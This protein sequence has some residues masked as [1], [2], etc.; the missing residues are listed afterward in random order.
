MSFGLACQACG[1]AYSS[2]GARG[3]FPD[4]RTIA[5]AVAVADARRRRA[6]STATPAPSSM[7]PQPSLATLGDWLDERGYGTPFR[8]HFIVP[9]TSA[10]WSTAAG[11][12]LEF[13]VA[14]LLRFLDNHGLIG[15]GNAPQWRVVRGG[16]RRY[17]ERIVERLPSGTR[18]ERATRW[19]PSP[20]MPTASRS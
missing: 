10:V 13:P 4:A 2:R 14:Y 18:P 19:P 7:A 9:I 6:A 11:R 1:L 17:V 15:Y 5:R 20:A 12:V 8:D 3:F 16:S